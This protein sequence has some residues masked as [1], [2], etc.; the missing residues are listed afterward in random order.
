MPRSEIEWDIGGG[1]WIAGRFIVHAGPPLR[2]D[3]YVSTACRRERAR[4]AASVERFNEPRT[5]CRIQRRD[6]ASEERA[7]AAGSG[8]SGGECLPTSTGDPDRAGVM[9][10]VGGLGHVQ[11]GRAKEQ[12]HSGGDDGEQDTIHGPSR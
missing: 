10:E 1:H 7:C 11:A 3:R 8:G 12:Q 6:K 2:D 9:H 5:V 4:P